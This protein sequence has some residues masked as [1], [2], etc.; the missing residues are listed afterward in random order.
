MIVGGVEDNARA[1]RQSLEPANVGHS[2]YPKRL[3]HQD[4]FAAF[5]QVGQQLELR[6]V[7]DAGQDGIVA[8]DGNVA[9]R[10]VI[11]GLIAR[12]G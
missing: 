9:D 1:S 6:L 4:M 12:V 5:D 11:G 2:G 3:F 10:P 8:V 7:G